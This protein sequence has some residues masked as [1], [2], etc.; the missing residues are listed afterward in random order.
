ML[1]TLTHLSRKKK[2]TSLILTTNKKECRGTCP[3]MNSCFYTSMNISIIV[4][5][6]YTSLIHT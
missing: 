6:S 1:A 2:Y 4:N 3:D 5:L